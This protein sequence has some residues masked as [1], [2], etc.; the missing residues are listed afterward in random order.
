MRSIF[1]KKKLSKCD[2][3]PYFLTQKAVQS[4][5]YIK[6]FFLKL[7]QVSNFRGNSFA[8]PT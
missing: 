2:V 3:S 1:L 5:Y 6:V 8:T 4:R 7:R